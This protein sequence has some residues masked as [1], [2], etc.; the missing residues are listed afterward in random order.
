MVTRLWA[1]LI[2]SKAGVFSLP[3]C[4]DWLWAHLASYPVGAMVHMLRAEFSGLEVEHS[5][6]RSAEVKCALSCT[7][8]SL[9]ICMV[10]CL[11]KLC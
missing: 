4:P 9:Y 3:Q 10:W 2:L 11:V 5:R 8:T 7:S 6:V 1:D